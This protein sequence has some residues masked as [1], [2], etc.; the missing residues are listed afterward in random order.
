M[1]AGDIDRGLIPLD[2]KAGNKLF[3]AIAIIVY[4]LTQAGRRT[5]TSPNEKANE[6]KKVLPISQHF[7][8]LE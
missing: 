2:L 3:E 7:A 5:A 6:Q 4:F 8:L 1:M